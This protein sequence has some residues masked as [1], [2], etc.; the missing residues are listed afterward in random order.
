VQ[1]A[2]LQSLQPDA[3]GQLGRGSHVVDVGSM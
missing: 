2:L 3:H 1:R